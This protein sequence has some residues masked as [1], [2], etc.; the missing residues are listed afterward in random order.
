MYNRQ[1]FLQRVIE[2]IEKVRMELGLSQASMAELLDMSHSGYKKMISGSNLR[3]DAYVFYKIFKKTKKFGFEIADD[4]EMGDFEFVSRLKELSPYQLQFIKG[5]V[6][7]ECQYSPSK[8]DSN[9]ISV[10][11]LTG[12]FEDGMILDSAF[13][14]KVDIGHYRA[15]YGDKISCGIKITSNHLNPVY[16][17]G[18]ILLIQRRPPRTNDTGIFINKE[19]GRAYL[20]KFIQGEPSRLETIN[21]YG[22]TF[23][24][25]PNNETDI[26]KW[27]KFGCV[28]A[29]VR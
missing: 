15:L 12:N 9:L 2:G 28:L 13:I 11:T 1:E 10:F 27:V 26:D 29:K 16:H 18:D 4:K 7:F 14:E 3:V 8:A 19:T 24:V 21:G 22:E 5:I 25:D 6:D 23:F 20:R 17:Q